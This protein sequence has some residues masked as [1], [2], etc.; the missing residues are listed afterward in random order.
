MS[1]YKNYLRDK[2]KYV[3][4][5]G[6]ILEYEEKN[7][8]MD[9]VHVEGTDYDVCWEYSDVAVSPQRL[10]QLTVNGFLEK[11]FDSNSTTKY[12]LKDREKVREAIE[13][14]GVPGEDGELKKIHEFPTEDELPEGLFDDVVGYDRVKWLLKR[15]IT[16]DEIT[17][18]LLVGPTGSAKTVFLMCINEHLPQSEFISGNPTSGP[19]VLDVMFSDTPKYMLIDEMDDMSADT[20]RVL[21]Q[22]TETGIVDETKVGKNRKLRTNTKTF[23]SAN[24]TRKIIDQMEDRFLDLHFQPYDRDEYIEVCTHILPRKE[25]SSK[26]EART[27]AELLWEA[28]N[29]GD[30]RRA[31]QVARLSRG[32]P[33]KVIEALGD[34]SSERELFY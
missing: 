4:G 19:G 14:I 11:L 16:T 2:P 7:K 8:G 34:Y 31:I 10:Y 20:Q 12:V 26:K 23:A 29:E 32:D 3:E 1:S 21:T 9:T 33:K 18:F 13:D 30:V 28:E 22:Y 27:I 5:L 6:R 25:G 24:S 17:N 15:G